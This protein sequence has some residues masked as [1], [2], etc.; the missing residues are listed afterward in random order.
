MSAAI[1][2]TFVTR[3]PS[4]NYEDKVL[5]VVEMPSVPE[6]SEEVVIGGKKYGVLGRSWAIVPDSDMQAVTVM[7]QDR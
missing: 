7:L 4:A 1:T 6:K 3:D 2:V 5:G